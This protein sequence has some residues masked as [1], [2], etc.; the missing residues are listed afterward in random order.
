[1]SLLESFADDLTT[2]GYSVD[3]VAQHRIRD[4][5]GYLTV[6]APIVIE[7]REF[8]GDLLV[9][10]YED[11]IDN[12]GVDIHSKAGHQ[13]SPAEQALLNEVATSQIQMGDNWVTWTYHSESNV[14]DNIPELVS[15]LDETFQGVR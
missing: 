12:H 9:N 2:E 3:R 6:H 8:E 4:K 14:E 1:M 7:N 11:H 5:L 10:V 15:T 13:F